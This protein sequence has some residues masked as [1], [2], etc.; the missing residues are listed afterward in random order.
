[1]SQPQEWQVHHWDDADYRYLAEHF[2]GVHH[3]FQTYGEEFAGRW[4]E[5]LTA[6]P[7]RDIGVGTAYLAL[8]FFSGS[9]V[10]ILFP[11]FM[12]I[13]LGVCYLL[14]FAAIYKRY[15]SI[16]AVVSLSVL[17]F[18][19]PQWELTNKLL[20][21]P[22]LRLFFLLYFSML[23]WS[24]RK[25]E[26]FLLIGTFLFSLIIVQFKAQWMFYGGLILPAFVWIN[27]RRRELK[28]ACM[29]I[30]FIVLLPL[31]LSM[32]HWIGWGSL[33]AVSGTGLHALWRTKNANLTY[34]CNHQLFRSALPRVCE[35]DI[36]FGSWSDFMHAQYPG[37]NLRQLSEDL[38]AASNRYYLT[39]PT[40]LLRHFWEGMVLAAPFPDVSPSFDGIMQGI[41]WIVV[42]VLIGGLVYAKT[43][44]L[45]WAGLSLWIVPAI[46]N[47]LATY[48]GRY[49]RP[50]AGIPIV[51]A[52]LI[53]VQ[54]YPLLSSRIR[55]IFSMA[56]TGKI[57]V[58][59]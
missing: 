30:V 55:N 42:A 13:A 59:Y 12:K 34:A 11:L 57:T 23:L 49:H 32:V 25:R 38:D 41:F 43:S 46:G 45:A 15:G 54:L 35:K 18:I 37:Q 26:T 56:R 51:I 27:L 7:F 22:F 50:M 9:S 31:S 24:G 52:F 8:K 3:D 21:E 14:F 53:I 6:V 5:Y 20:P 40:E 28:K 16:M 48:D 1:M 39:V 10:D 29:V 17:C 47:M 36:R 44:F 2:F 58:V 33:P 4:G 19:F